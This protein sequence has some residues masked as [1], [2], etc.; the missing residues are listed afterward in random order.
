MIGRA[1][2]VGLLL[3]ALEVAQGVVRVRLLNRRVGNRRARQIGV[4][5]GS[6]LVV[7]LAWLTRAWVGA[8]TVPQQFAVGLVWL[9]VL[10]ALDIGFGRLV[11]HVS[12]RRIGREF[13]PRQG[14]W[15]AFGLLVVALAP[16]LVAA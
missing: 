1:L 4:V 15:L 14:G 3:A 6:A 13:D 9:L 10:L 16:W 8:G 5:T 2:I 12:W 7:L 11:F